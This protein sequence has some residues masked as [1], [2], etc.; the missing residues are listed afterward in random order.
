[1]HI[2]R[3]PMNI[4]AVDPSAAAAK[5]AIAAQRASEIRKKLAKSATGLDSATTPDEAFIV[6]HWLSTQ[7]DAIQNRATGEAEQHA[8]ASGRVSEFG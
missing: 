4:A 3:T 7:L 1:M 8:S 5:K 2:L 6:G